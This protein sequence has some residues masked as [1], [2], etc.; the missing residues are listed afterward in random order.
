MA[1]IFSR[2]AD[3]YLRVGLLLA[4][5]TAGGGLLLGAGYIRS[6]YATGE[7]LALAQ[8]VPFSH[9][10][11]AGQLGIDCRYCHDQVETAAS[12]GY[13]PTH[14]CMTCHSQLW[15]HA[16]ELA[17]VRAS[18]A[19][20]TPL[21]WN[22]V[23]DLPDYVYF[24]H[25]IHVAAGVGCESCHG[26]VVDMPRVYQAESLQMGWC[27]NC[28][29]HPWNHLRPASQEFEFHWQ[30]PPD[31][32]QQGPRLMAARGIEPGQLDNCYTCHR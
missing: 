26:E 11:H 6:D 18:L 16:D 9:K 19:S 5:M 10:H 21:R 28:H 24:N 13:P 32:E 27:L 29:R 25:S 3:A 1:Q 12:A 17:P 31:Q 7:D 20:G 30:P 4:V 15:T 2:A 23:N 8:P 14:T 22:R